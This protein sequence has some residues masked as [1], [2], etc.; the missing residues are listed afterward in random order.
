MKITLKPKD[1]QKGQTYSGTD[2]HEHIHIY[3]QHNINTCEH[4]Y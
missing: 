4:L 2:R 3:L 1:K